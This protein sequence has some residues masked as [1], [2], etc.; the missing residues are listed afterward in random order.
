[1]RRWRLTS[2]FPDMQNPARVHLS[3]PRR[4]TVRAAGPP[5]PH[6]ASG[7]PTG[8]ASDNAT[9]WDELVAFLSRPSA[10]G[11][12]A[13]VT[14]IETHISR[15][16]LSERYAYKLKKPVRLPF[17]DF[18]ALSLRHA[19]CQSEVV[20]NRM[21]APGVYLDVIPVVERGR[22]LHLGGSGRIVDWLVKMRRLPAA[23]ALPAMLARGEAHRR[24]AYALADR[25]ASFYRTAPRV[26]T[27]PEGYAN[28]LIRW[29]DA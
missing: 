9:S 4:H 27:T 29:I 14:S 7:R 22:H 11:D 23:S 17:V 25:L 19:A 5:R 10:Y 2:F 3:R 18:S 24:H 1:M 8:F 20:L 6:H 13:P 21:L 28:R 12:V 26:A 16:F 15:V